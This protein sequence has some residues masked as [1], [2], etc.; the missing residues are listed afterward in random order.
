MPVPGRRQNPSK[1]DAAAVGEQCAGVQGGHPRMSS[2]A[3]EAPSTTKN[4]AISPRPG[5]GLRYFALQIGDIWRGATRELTWV[6]R[7][8]ETGRWPRQESAP[9]QCP[10]RTQ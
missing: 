2:V 6:L 3:K 5:Y 7:R 9:R 10:L 8:R 1:K 4:Q